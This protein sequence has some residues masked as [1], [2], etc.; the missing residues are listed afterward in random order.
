MKGFFSWKNCEFYPGVGV[1][2]PFHLLVLNLYILRE[3]EANRHFTIKTIVKGRKNA[4][5]TT[6]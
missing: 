6:V 4:Y 2:M 5:D 3:T 1:A